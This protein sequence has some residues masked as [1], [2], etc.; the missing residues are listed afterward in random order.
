MVQWYSFVKVSSSSEITARRSTR[1]PCHLPATLVPATVRESSEPCVIVL[2]NLHGC[3]ARFGRPIQVGT[4][5]ELGGLPAGNNVTARV[6]N[7]ISMGQYE[8]FWLLGLA[9]EQP[10]NV[11]G[12]EN[13]PADWIASSLEA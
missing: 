13:P 7:C 10:A 6:V 1:I 12:V 3:A 4:P 11:W 2:V 8:N 9:L 5:V